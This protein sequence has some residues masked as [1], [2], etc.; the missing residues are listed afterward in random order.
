MVGKTQKIKHSINTLWL[1][2]TLVC[3]YTWTLD[4]QGHFMMFC[5]FVGTGES[6][7]HTYTIML[8]M[9]LETMATKG[10]TDTLCKRCGV[11][12][13]KLVG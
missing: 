10:E 3:S 6:N 7:L 12:K 2:T 11:K 5:V 1:L 13:Q 4:I 8:S 9:L